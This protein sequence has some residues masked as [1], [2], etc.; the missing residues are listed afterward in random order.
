MPRLLLLLLLPAL[1][2]APAVPAFA[3]RAPAVPRAAWW[4]A[5]GVL[6]GGSLALDGEI[7]STVPPGGGTEWEPLTDRL[8]HLGSPRYLL[9]AVAGGYAAGALAPGSG[10]S[11]ASAH[12]LGALLAGGMANGALKTAVGRERPAGGDPHSFRPFSLE[13]RWQSFPSGHA[14][15]AFSVAAAL[16]EEADRGWVSALSYGTA[17]L[18]A[19]SRIYEDK[20]WTSDAVAGAL[21]GA[22]SSRAALGLIHRVSPHGS[23]EAAGVVLTGNGFVVHI[24]TR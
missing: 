21:V 11:T 6:L 13:N 23:G 17:S 10:L 4:A 15:V 20:H 8:N 9:P 2:L 22:L 5:A 24:P 3:Q 18:V 14:V 19:W 12:V 16:S 1:L 7:R